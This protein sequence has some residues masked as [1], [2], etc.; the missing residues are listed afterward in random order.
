MKRYIYLIFLLGFFACQEDELVLY[1]QDKDALQFFLDEEKEINMERE[2][3]FATASY[4]KEVNG[5]E[6]TFYYGD[7]LSELTEKVILELQGFPTPDEREYKLKAVLVE[8]QDSS[9]V[10]EVRFAP[11][12]S[13]AP[14][15]LRDTVE[16]TL[17]RPKARGT[18]TVGI[19]VDTAG[20]AAFFEKGVAEQSVLQLDIKDVYEKPEEWDARAD[21]LGPFSEEKYAFMVTYSQKLFSRNENHM[22]HETDQY[23]VEL[24]KALEKFNAA[25]PGNE[26]DFDFPV[27][28]KPVWWDN[29]K[30]YLGDFSEE[31]YNF[32]ADILKGELLAENQKLEYWNLVFRYAAEKEG[33]MEFSFPRVETQASW[34]REVIL[35]EFSIEKQEYVIMTLFPKT[36]YVISE[37]TWMFAGAVL[38]RAVDDYNLNNSKEPLKFNFPD[39]GEPAWWKFRENVLGLFSSLKRDVVVVAELELAIERGSYNISMLTAPDGWNFEYFD[40]EKVIAAVKEYNKNHPDNQITDMPG[41][42]GGAPAWWKND[43]LGEWDSEKESFIVNTMAKLGQYYQS[44]WTLIKDWN[45]VFRYEL[46]LYND[47]NQNK[48][49]SFDFPV[50]D[51]KPSYWDNYAYLGEYTESKL[52]FLWEILAVKNYGACDENAFADWNYVFGGSKEGVYNFIIGEYA[53][54]YESFIADFANANPK[55]E[56]FDF[57]KTYPGN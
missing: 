40:L 28:S 9:K 14:N 3:N 7:S 20:S 17:L 38:R 8:G 11:Y 6:E 55:P 42:E 35:G 45:P 15:A 23:N 27:T 18:Y 10:G 44:E 48:P 47:K 34:W 16:I 31:K 22:W 21:W 53:V 39:E 43:M 24:R 41:L 12:Y 30:K 32:M 13:L 36:N 51:A 25:N 56:V 46:A 33:I 52:V 54:K 49:Y 50:I 2:I 37:D 19:V 57:P 4:T 5:L 26:K 29:Q 1:T